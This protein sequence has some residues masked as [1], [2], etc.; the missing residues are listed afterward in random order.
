MTRPLLRGSGFTLI[1]LLAASALA[2]LLMLVLFQVI[3]SL[4]RSR[5]A[6][7]RAAAGEMQ[8]AA[9]TAWKSDLLDLIRWDVTNAAEINVKPGVMT[10]TGHAALD[11]R[12]LAAKQEPVTIVYAIERR[13]KTGC[14]LRRQVRRDGASAHAGWSELVCAN[15]S[16]FEV[17]PVL[18]PGSQLSS[19]SSIRMRIEGP[20]GEVLDEVIVVK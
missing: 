6:L 3:G 9:Q 14:L 2:A 19:S 16:R 20:A 18:V 8:S 11:R 12:S 10:L 13:G 15:V 17:W 7:E 1:E 4:G 5:A